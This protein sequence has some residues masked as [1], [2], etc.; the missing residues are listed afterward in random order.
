[1]RILQTTPR[2]LRACL[3][4]ALFVVL[5]ALPTSALAAAT[6]T[7]APAAKPASKAAPAPAKPSAKAPAAAKPVHPLPDSVLIRID[8]REDVT[9]R[10][11][12]RAV[13]LLGGNPDSLT[14]GDRDRFLE[15]VLEQ[16][17]L[18]AQAV[19]AGLPWTPVDSAR[20]LNERDNTLVRAAPQARTFHEAAAP[21]QCRAPPLRRFIRRP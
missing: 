12:R 8:D 3:R 13:R 5:L 2:S 20:Y 18:A 10:R 17:L 7:A 9:V 21:H 16:R 4:G 6:G 19:K 15:L 11:F 1:M 14:P